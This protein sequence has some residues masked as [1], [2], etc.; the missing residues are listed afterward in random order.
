MAEDDSRKDPVPTQ[1]GDGRNRYEI[2]RTAHLGSGHFGDVYMGQHYTSRKKVAVKLEHRSGSIARREW[3]VM[4]AMDGN[5]APRVYYTGMH[6][7]YYVMVMDL[8]GPTLQRLLESS[9]QLRFH[10][11][12]VIGVGF[13]TVVKKD[14]PRT[15]DV[16]NVMLFFHVHVFRPSASNFFENCTQKAMY[17]E[18][19][20]PR[21]SC[22]VQARDQR[23][24]IPR[25]VSI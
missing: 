16:L 14:S 4:R 8:L 1:V 12:M 19:S 15:T 10:Q 22:V 20:S 2:I 5:G 11:V 21:T 3:E 7:R 13:L 24:L 25:R 9:R 6:G 17:M 18:T 23:S